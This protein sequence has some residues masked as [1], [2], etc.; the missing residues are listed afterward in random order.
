MICEESLHVHYHNGGVWHGDAIECV[1][2]QVHCTLHIVY[3]E[4]KF[5]SNSCV[6][7][8]VPNKFILVNFVQS[9]AHPEISHTPGQTFSP[10]DSTVYFVHYF[11][12]PVV[13]SFGPYS[14]LKLDTNL[15]CII[16]CLELQCSPQA[17][18]AKRPPML[19]C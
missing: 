10:L 15:I 7:P 11:F 3:P 17:L 12:P 6:Y 18:S 8:K 2:V 9:V 14:C 13:L 4:L 5:H 16:H 19:Y 1:Q